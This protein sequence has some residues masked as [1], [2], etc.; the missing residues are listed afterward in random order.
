MYYQHLRYFVLFIV[1]LIILGTNSVKAQTNESE[2]SSESSKEILIFRTSPG[3]EIW[4]EGWFSFQVS[5]FSPLLVVKVN[6]FAQMVKEDADWAEYE[7]PFY[8]KK[9]KNLFKIFVQT[10]TGQREQVFI[11]TYEPVEKKR[12]SSPPLDGIVMLGQTNSDNILNVQESKTKTS[13]VKNDL[14]L[15]GSYAF[16]INKE[17]VFALNAVFKFDRHQNRSLVGEEV[18]FR[19]F[20][21]EYRH[22]NLL[23]FEFS[24]GLGQNVISLK[25]VDSA[26]TYNTGEFKENIRSFYLSVGGKKSWGRNFSISLK[27]Q[28]DSQ[29]KVKTDTEDGNLTLVSLGAKSRWEN[30]RFQGRLDSKSTSLK[31]FTKD[32]QSTLLDTG[33]SYSWTP[34]VFSLNYQNMNQQYKNSDLA[35]NLVMQIKKDEMSL[36]CKYSFSNSTIIGGDLKQIKQSSNDT[37]KVYQANQFTMTYIWMF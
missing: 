17:S 31:D 10:K 32:Y 24:A 6:G 37:T 2:Q 21:S 14:L 34:W 28:L 27:I 15:S 22:K 12:K 11:V 9:G 13:A 5:S 20:G 1:L 7:I 30:F 3:K 4:A 26:G 25:D 35:N 36:N 18:L 8:L 33:A 23:S 19:Q 29:D 16:G